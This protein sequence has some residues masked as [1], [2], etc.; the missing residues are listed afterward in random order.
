MALWLMQ[1]LLA[2]RTYLAVDEGQT[3]QEARERVS[4][5]DFWVLRDPARPTLPWREAKQAGHIGYRL[6]IEVGLEDEIPAWIETVGATLDDPRSWRAAGRDLVR[7][8]THARFDV[9]LARPRTVDRL[10]RPLRTGGIYSC[11]RSGRAALNSMRWLEG[12][13]PWGDDLAGYRTYM[14]NHEVGHLLGMPHQ[15]CDAEGEVAAVMLQQT[16]GL[17]GCTANGWPVPAEL[18]RLRARWAR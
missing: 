16:K 18:E 2:A 13:R 8:D 6:L 4:G 5:R 7:V 17:Q 9:I 12:A 15:R 3:L 10:C 14:I 11:G 1:W